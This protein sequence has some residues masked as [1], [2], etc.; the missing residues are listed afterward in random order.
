LAPA[1]SL[2]LGVEGGPHGHGASASSCQ[3][4]TGA[5]TASRHRALVLGVSVYHHMIMVHPL[6]DGHAP[7]RAV[8]DLLAD[9][10]YTVSLVL[11]PDGGTFQAA[12]DTFVSSLT[13]DCRVVVYFTGHSVSCQGTTYLVPADGNVSCSEGEWAGFFRQCPGLSIQKVSDVSG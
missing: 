3:Y 4:V 10:G 6:A 7:A 12:V 8:A 5:C 13:F 9:E 11:S 2:R 1:E